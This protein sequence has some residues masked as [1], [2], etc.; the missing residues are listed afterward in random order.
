MKPIP[1][2]VSVEFLIWRD[3]TLDNQICRVN[4]IINYDDAFPMDR[5]PWQSL[6]ASQVRHYYGTAGIEI[7]SIKHL[8]NL[9]DWP[10]L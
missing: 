5:Q 7:H 2:I 9:E 10:E 3:D 8:G 4:V 6:A 1:K